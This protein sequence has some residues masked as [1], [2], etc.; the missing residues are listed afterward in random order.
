MSSPTYAWPT[1]RGAHC[2]GWLAGLIHSAQTP[3]LSVAGPPGEPVNALTMLSASCRI[4]VRHT[5]PH[6]PS[7]GVH[8]ALHGGDRHSDVTRRASR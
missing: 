3:S 2:G 8:R 4:S 7:I 5:A 6:R 1:M